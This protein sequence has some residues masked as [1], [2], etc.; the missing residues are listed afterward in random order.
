MQAKTGNLTNMRALSGYI[1]TD[2]GEKLAFSIIVNNHT[3]P[4]TEVDAAFESI[5]MRIVR[6]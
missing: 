4:G 3:A 5:L 2:A 1:E 6:R